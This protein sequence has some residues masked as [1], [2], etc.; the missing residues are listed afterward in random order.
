[1][2]AIHFPCSSDYFGT[3]DY[4]KGIFPLAK[5]QRGQ[6]LLIL[7]EYFAAESACLTKGPAAV[8]YFDADLKTFQCVYFFITLYF[9]KD[10]K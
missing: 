4:Y 3:W 9:R 1:M 8:G 7:R 6:R 10:L 2:L 5:V